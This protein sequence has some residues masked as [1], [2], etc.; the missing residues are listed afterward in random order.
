MKIVFGEQFAMCAAL[1]KSSIG[2]CKAANRRV[3]ER[4]VG[5]EDNGRPGGKKLRANES[6]AYSKSLLKPR[7]ADVAPR[8]ARAL[9]FVK[10]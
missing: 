6:Q 3:V 7:L 2:Q 9:P 1:L 4:L 8:G 5:S 10:S